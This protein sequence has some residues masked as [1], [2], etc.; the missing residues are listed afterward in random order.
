MADKEAVE[1]LRLGVKAWNSAREEGRFKKPDLADADLRDR[2]LTGANLSAVTLRSADL[3]RAKLT[4]AN[5]EGAILWGATLR[6]ADLRMAD[7]KSTDLR[8]ADL[9]HAIL[10][11]AKFKGARLSEANLCH[12]DLR[13]IKELVLDR[14]MIRE[15]SFSP[16]PSDLWSGLRRRY[17]GSK[18]LLNLLLFVLFILPY[19]SKILFWG[20]VSQGEKLAI[21]AVKEIEVA[22]GQENRKLAA[23]LVSL[24]DRIGVLTEEDGAE[25]EVMLLTIDQA[26]ELHTLAQDEW[27]AKYDSYKANNFGFKKYKIWQLLL[28]LDRNDGSWFVILL[29]VIYNVSRVTLTLKIVPLEESASRS[30][31]SPEAKEYLWLRWL[32]VTVQ[33]L[34]Y[35][36]ISAALFYS[37]HW[38]IEPDVWMPTT[39]PAFN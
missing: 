12:A 26:I 35:V 3:S 13:G 24:R 20:G 23:V 5:L 38:L 19:A 2:D 21:T 25:V 14:T 8:F 28:G 18:A 36:S 29:L 37:Y 17:T 32:D 22:L 33:V 34:M 16:R 27:K 31:Y 7:L 11:Q 39:A 10:A 4:N 6:G 1:T 15:A 9:E 30:G